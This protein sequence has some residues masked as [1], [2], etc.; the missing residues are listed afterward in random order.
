MSTA[1]PRSSGIAP[2]VIV[3]RYVHADP[4]LILAPFPSWPRSSLA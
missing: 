1:E 2:I 3:Y 4:E